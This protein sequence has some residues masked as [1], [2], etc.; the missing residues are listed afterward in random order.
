M[1]QD[2]EPDGNVKVD[3]SSYARN[4]YHVASTKKSGPSLF[5]IPIPVLLPIVANP[6][7]LLSLVF[8]GHG[9]YHA[10]A[11]QFIQIHSKLLHL[12]ACP[13]CFPQGVGSHALANHSQAM[14]A[15]VSFIPR[16][17]KHA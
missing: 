9:Q 10:N 12:G 4:K 3:A 7:Q 8:H 13:S 17:S 1:L 6:V 14:S 5:G 15:Y 16:L 11:F 2:V